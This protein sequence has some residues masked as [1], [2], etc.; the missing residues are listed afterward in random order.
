MPRHI[1]NIL[2]AAL[3]AILALVAGINGYIHHQFKTNID[4]TLSSIQMFAQVKYSELSTSIISGKVELKNVRVSAQFL[5]EQINLGNITLETPGFLYMLSGPENARKGEFPDHLGFAIDD[6]YIDMNGATAEWLNKLVKRM[7]P[8]YGSQ[9]KICGGKSIFGPS[10]YK[11][12]GYARVMSNMRM[13]YDF[14]KSRKTLTIDVTGKTRNMGNVSARALVSNIS[15]MKSANMMQGGLPQLTSV[16]VNY[17]DD[18]YTPRI[19]KYCSDLDKTKKEEFI[20]AEVKQPDE[21]FYMLW[22]FSPGDGLR[23]AYKD[24]LL[25]PD[26]VTLTLAP[27]KEFNPMMLSMMSSNEIIDA[28]NVRLKINGLLVT[29][30][31]YK[32]PPAG[33]IENFERRLANSLDF[34]SLMRGEPVKEPEPVIEPKVV[35]KAVAAYHPISLAQAPQHINDFVRIT[36]KSGNERKG[37]LLR[38]DQNNL[39][40]QKKV[41]GGK[42]TMTVPRSKIKTIE[43]YFSK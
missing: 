29:D 7:Q 35:V 37:Q 6:F 1:R 20:E 19:I 13:A 24:F 4:N 3:L 25:K 38:L 31:S 11:E 18:T 10:D 40:V 33:F 23:D 8:V 41:S 36:T 21:Y 26:L 12:M 42:F 2:I 15:S 22:G 39:Y 32:A 5:P 34:N 16:E 17:K 27:S 14:N 28:L 9:R 30:L 43:A